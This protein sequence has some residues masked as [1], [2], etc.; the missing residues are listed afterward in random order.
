MYAYSTQRVT[1]RSLGRPRHAG[2]LRA[3]ALLA[4]MGL[5]IAMPSH[6]IDLLNLGSLG[7]PLAEALTQLSALTPGIKALV[8]L[9]AFTVALIALAALRNLAP[10]LSYVG[11]A[12]FAAAG[13]AV[14]G[15]V[16]GAVV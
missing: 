9:V 13:L 16:V 3:A 1:L 5:A 15:A 6:A 11:V 14:G 8:V 4:A 10:V 12:I 2:G 7:G